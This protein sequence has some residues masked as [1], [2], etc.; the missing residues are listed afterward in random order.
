[1]QIDLNSDLG[2]SFGAWQMGDDAAMLKIVSSAN[3]ACGAHAG[4]PAGILHTLKLAQKHQ[5]TVGAHIGYPD[6]AGFG[7]RNFAISSADLFASLV[8]QIGALQALAQT[9]QT[10]VKYVKPHGALYN[11][12]A[13]DLEHAQI[14]IDAILAV[15]PKL[16]LLALAN[17]PLVAFAR[18]AGL[19]VIGEVFADR[20]YLPT[21][22]LVSRQEAN[23]VLHDL[24]LI[25]QRMLQFAQKGTIE[26]IDGSL[27]KIEGASICVHGDSPGAVAIAAQVKQEL[28]AQ[29]VQIQ[30]FYS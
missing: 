29:Q 12:I 1:M 4:D 5:V 24:D 14:V 21:G 3:I 8:Y 10:A 15:N 20:S 19:T 7:R 22:A 2:E 17:S 13:Y 26:A 6:L 30:S 25:A 28:Q 27:L 23:A 16:K 9:A 11:R 18:Q